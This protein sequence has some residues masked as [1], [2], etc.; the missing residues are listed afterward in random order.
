MKNKK[1][2]TT[3]QGRMSWLE[4][5]NDDFLSGKVPQDFSNIWED[6]DE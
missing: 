5:D 1:I 6:D 4:E 3:H 2:P